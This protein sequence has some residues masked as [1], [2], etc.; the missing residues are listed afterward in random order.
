MQVI[1]LLKKLKNFILKIKVN[2]GDYLEKLCDYL[3]LDPVILTKSIVI[4]IVFIGI[5]VLMVIYPILF[6]ILLLLVLC[7]IMIIGIYTVIEDYD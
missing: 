5:V 4:F 1:E 6:V 2:V 7:V 3:H